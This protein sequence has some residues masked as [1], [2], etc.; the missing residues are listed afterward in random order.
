M[1]DQGRDY[2]ADHHVVSYFP[3]SHGGSVEMWLGGYYNGPQVSAD[4]ALAKSLGFNAVRTVFAA[5]TYFPTP[6]ATMLAN[7]VDY[8][9]RAKQVGIK[10]HLVLFDLWSNLGLIAASKT[11]LSTV[12]SALPDFNNIVVLELKNEIHFSDTSTYSG[13]FDSGWPTGTTQYTQFG[14]VALVWAQQ[15]IP[16]ARTLAPGKPVSIS[17]TRPPSG[18]LQ[19]FVSATQGT[20]AEPDFYDWHCYYSTTAAMVYGNMAAAKAVVGSSR[21]FVS[22]TGATTTPAGT[23]GALQAEQK[24][25]DYLQ[26]ARWAAGQLGLPEP[27][28]WCLLDLNASVQFPSGQAFGLFTTSGAERKSAGLFR[29][30]PLGTAVPPID[31][32]MVFGQAFLPDTN[33]NYLPPRLYAYKGNGGAQPIVTAQDGV[34]LKVTGS[35]GTSG[36]DNQPAVEIDP[37]APVVTPGAFYRLSAV[38]SGTGAIGSPSFSIAWYDLLGAYIPPSDGTG[39]ALT[40][41]P[42]LFSFVADAPAN[43]AIAKLFIRVGYNN[44]T[45]WVSSVNWALA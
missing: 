14:Q 13:G 43:A 1:Y 29:S 26:T 32:S 36:G 37:A 39:L 44:G 12:L 8:Y 22:E 15:M 27:G 35:A 38:L 24:Q 9:A 11:W 20:S 45:I 5:Y 41:T 33:G 3:V 31:T 17:T 4:L 18:D 28:I 42:T 21:M 25:L 2:L 23:L 34:R 19:A 30:Y 6:D 40:S 7:L 10:V 16:Y